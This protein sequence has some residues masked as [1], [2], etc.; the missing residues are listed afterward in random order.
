MMEQTAARLQE[1]GRAADAQHLRDGSPHWLRHTFAKTALL[2]GQSMRDV[3]G[4]LGHA[5]LATTIIYTEQEAR[6]LIDASG[7]VQPGSVAMEA[8]A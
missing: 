8:L 2:T 6:D 1:A 4:A 5:D 7:R 3:A